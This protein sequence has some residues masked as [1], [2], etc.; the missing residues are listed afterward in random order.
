MEKEAVMEK[1]KIEA[2]VRLS[3]RQG[4]VAPASMSLSGPEG[5]RVVV[6]AAKRIIET[7]GDVIKA[8]AKR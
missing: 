4:K 6:N 2:A 3:K 7:H 5:K 8:L 1:L